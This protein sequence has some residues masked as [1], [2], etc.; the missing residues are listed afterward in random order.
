M[1]RWWI[2]LLAL[3]LAPHAMAEDYAGYR[4]PQDY[5]LTAVLISENDVLTTGWSDYDGHIDRPWHVT[6]W[7]GRTVFRDL[8]YYPGGAVSELGTAKFL[9][10]KDGSFKVMICSRTDGGTNYTHCRL[11]DWTEQGLENPIAIPLTP[12]AADVRSVT[13]R[14]YGRRAVTIER[15]IDGALT[16]NVYD[17]R[18]D[19]IC[20]FSTVQEQSAVL[21]GLLEIADGV[22][23]AEFRFGPPETNTLLCL[24][25]SGLRWQ[26]ALAEH[27]GLRA[28]GRGG[29][30]LSLGQIGSSYTPYRIVRLDENGAETA[31]KIIS[32]NRVVVGLGSPVWNEQERTYTF[33]GYAVANSRKVYT[34]YR[35]VTD[36]SLT[37][38]AWDV[39]DLAKSF[40][41]YSPTLLR[42][43]GGTD[44][45]FSRKIGGDGVALVPFDALPRS[46]ENVGL[47]LDAK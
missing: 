42:T 34:V 46:T 31:Q 41:D 32:G 4:F 24:D 17:T 39:R 27:A 12:S 26:K 2:L 20:R 16:L 14:A 45:V 7:R 28:D 11:Y 40:G 22:F 3:L 21:D 9:V 30:V 6:W 1:K 19:R 44:F 25:A 13:V 33:L 36:E 5:P 23:L 38:L 29:A 10:E 8:P 15:H 37:P 35:L 43:P 18:G 47:T